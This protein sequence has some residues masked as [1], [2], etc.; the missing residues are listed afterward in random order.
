MQ[1][2]TKL[3][4]KPIFSIIMPAYNAENVIE[5][6]IKSVLEQSFS[7]FE[8]IIIDDGSKDHTRQIAE[9]YME[10]DQRVKVISQP[11]RGASSARN[12]GIKCSCGRYLMFI[13]ADDRY[14]SNYL[15][16]VF[17]K[18]QS[19]EQMVIVSFDLFKSGKYQKKECYINGDGG[20]ISISD[21]LGNM[22]KYHDQAYWGANWNKV[23]CADIIKNNEIKFQDNIS[24][25]EDFYFNLCYL[26]YVK[27]I[28]VIQDSLYDY[29]ADTVDSLSKQKRLAYD[30]CRQYACIIDVYDRLCEP[31]VS[32][33]ENY[34]ILRDRFI[35][36]AMWDT[37]WI[38]FLN[39]RYSLAKIRN[40]NDFMRNSFPPLYLERGAIHD[41]SLVDLFSNSVLNGRTL[42]SMIL[43]Y[44]VYVKRITLKT[45]RRIIKHE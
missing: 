21:Y 35:K 30:Y 14:H 26:Q 27:I 39:N 41:N 24:I 10:A 28:L 23:Y 33:I 31:Y 19:D 5:L 3:T 32:E 12:H 20:R 38:G 4:E 15:S 34:Q 40:T 17:G 6:A 18:I 45:I 1:K 44:T 8:M 13:D 9:K 25:G 7:D 42:V 2:E 43:L 11:N 29:E 16:S 22:I 36:I 37:A